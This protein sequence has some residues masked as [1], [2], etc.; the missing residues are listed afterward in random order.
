[1]RR[2]VVV[3]SNALDDRTRQERSIETDS[4]AA[5]KKVFD[6][7]ECL[8][9]A[10]VDAVVVSL[11]RGRQDGSG[12]YFRSVARRVGNVPVVYGALVHRR[13]LSECVSLVSGAA[14][15]FRLRRRRH[16]NTV[17]FY[18]RTAAYIPALVVAFIM[19]HRRVLDLEDGEVGRGGVAERALARATVLVFE[20]LCNGG[21]LLACSALARA[22]RLRP[23]QCYYG[24]VRRAPARAN[25]AAPL[26][27]VLLGGTVARDTGGSLLAE[28]IRI[29]RRRGAESA[30]RMSIVITGKGDSLVEFAALAAQEGWPKV[31]VR[32]RTSD[33]EYREIVS[34]S[35][36]GLA[37]KPSSGGFANTTFPSKVV[38]FASAGLLV[39]S[40]DISDVR[41]VLGD[42]ALYVDPETAEYLAD[43]LQWI[44][45]HMLEAK[46]IALR[47][48]AI[49]WRRC[50]PSKVAGSL[51]GF[52]LEGSG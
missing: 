26:L 37:L 9:R 43:Q 38:E 1:M 48:R 30:R 41:G 51:A 16:R 50:A 40:T 32:G 14:M 44:A 33:A 42:G 23:V 34:Q 4:P 19:R 5:S 11:G 31:V 2:R 24:T 52:L 27:Q 12:R 47:G 45:T 29:L 10:G 20:L 46:A 17:L 21:A 6:L 25:W 8:R 36:V 13:W 28:A 22:T 35:H 49:V 15:V 18:N 7:C 3:V 39:V